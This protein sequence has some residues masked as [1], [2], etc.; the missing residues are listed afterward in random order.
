[1]ADTEEL[2]FSHRYQVLLLTT[3]LALEVGDEV[4]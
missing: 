2:D 3:Q 1:M 4:E